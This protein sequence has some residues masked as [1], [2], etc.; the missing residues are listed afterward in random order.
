MKKSFKIAVITIIALAFITAGVTGLLTGCTEA[1][2]VN[3]D[4]SKQSVYFNC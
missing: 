2:R 3:H 1:D 4:I